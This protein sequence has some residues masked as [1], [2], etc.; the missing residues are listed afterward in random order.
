LAKWHLQSRFENW[1]NVGGKIEYV[2]LFGIVG[3]LV[4]LIACINFMNLA[5]ARSEKAAR[6]VGRSQAWGPGGGS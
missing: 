4:L 6:E 2:R 5:T 1:A 3:L